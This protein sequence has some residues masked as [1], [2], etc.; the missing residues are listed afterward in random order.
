MT[1][2]FDI[3][4]AYWRNPQPFEQERARRL[5]MFNAAMAAHDARVR[6]EQERRWAKEERA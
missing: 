2:N 3:I 1:D 5:A 4:E 6:A